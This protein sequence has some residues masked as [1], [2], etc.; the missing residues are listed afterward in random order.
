MKIY[1]IIGGWHYDSYE[2]MAVYSD[3]EKAKH[4]LETIKKGLKKKYYYDYVKI[5]IHEVKR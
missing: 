1:I 3:E 2:I 4:K 5:E